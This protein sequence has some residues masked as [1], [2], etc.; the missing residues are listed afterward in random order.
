[1]GTLKSYR[2][3]DG[4]TIS[5]R[6]DKEVI[7]DLRYGSFNKASSLEAYIKETAHACKLQNGSIIRI[8]S[9]KHFISDLVTNNFIT[10]I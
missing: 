8:D 4:D 5:G 10:Q 2:L 1:M 7:E 3:Q 9:H 6:T